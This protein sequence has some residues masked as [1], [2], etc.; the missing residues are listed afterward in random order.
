VDAVRRQLRLAALGALILTVLAGTVLAQRFW[1]QAHLPLFSV[2]V[3]LNA[4]D[5]PVEVSNSA[6]L[7]SGSRVLDAGPG[8]RQVAA[9]QRRWLAAGTVPAIA[10]LGPT[11][12]FG[13][14][15]LDIDTLSKPYGVAVAGWRQPWRY[16]WPR[17][18]AFV[19]GALAR[20]GHQTD[21]VRIL[22]FL[23]RV[24]RSDGTFQ[25]RSSPDGSDPPGQRAVQF[26]NTGWAAWALA[27]VVRPLPLR[28]SRRVLND[29]RLLLDR[30]T[31]ALLTLTRYGTA[32]PPAS[33]DYWE[34]REAEPT[35]AGSAAILVGLR[36]VAS[37]YRV[38]GEPTRARQLTSTADRFESVILDQFAADGFPRH[39]GGPRS[40]VDLGVALLMPPFAAVDD[41]R[42]EAAWRGSLRYLSRPAGGLAPGGSWRRDGISWTNVTA[43]YAMV[44]SCAAPRQATV[45]RLRWLDRHRTPLGSVPEK[46]RADGSPASVAPLA[47]TAAAVLITADQLRHGC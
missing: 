30:S 37:A 43:T 1:A 10:E 28:Q 27:E 9:R 23:Q 11:T 31:A 16:V 24:Q 13:D 18:V 45:E 42:V 26:D 46:V 32:L 41:P 19:A 29:H 36:S 21:A 33:P 40:S 2:T 39:P 14:A 8:S 5:A 4:E 44:E 38:I 20:T 17:D 6:D 47:W 3:A 35:L 25:P 7:L 22:D 34:T 12:M 15:M